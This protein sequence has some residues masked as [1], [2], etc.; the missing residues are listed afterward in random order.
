[1]RNIWRVSVAAGDD[2][3]A[4]C[5]ENRHKAMPA[6]NGFHVVARCLVFDEGIRK[7]HDIPHSQIR[8]GL[9]FGN[10][11]KDRTRLGPRRGHPLQTAISEMRQ[12]RGERSISPL[13]QMTLFANMRKAVTMRGHAPQTQDKH[14]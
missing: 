13:G 4:H 2:S 14:C 6:Q 9:L 3:C 5:D 11:N 12:W 8:M 1:M 7:D 10:V